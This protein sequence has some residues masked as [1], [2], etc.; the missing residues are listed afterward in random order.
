VTLEH[1]DLENFGPDAPRMRE[2]FDGPGAWDSTLAEY[3]AGV[4][5]AA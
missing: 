2:T 5:S 4:A 3:A 1:R